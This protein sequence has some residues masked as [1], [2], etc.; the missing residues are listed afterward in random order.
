MK[1]KIG[2][3]ETKDTQCCCK[4]G[5]EE[6]VS[7][8]VPPPS[9]L[10]LRLSARLHLGLHSRRRRRRRSEPEQESG[11]G[12]QQGVRPRHPVQILRARGEEEGG[13]EGEEE[14]RGGPLVPDGVHGARQGDVHLKQLKKIVNTTGTKAFFSTG[15][16]PVP[17]DCSRFLV[18]DL[19]PPGAPGPFRGTRFVCP[20]G[21]RFG[22]LK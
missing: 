16:F 10:L 4:D 15:T 2:P 1:S 7:A 20:T 21:T 3:K 14:G 19:A 17:G 13:Q 11:Q 12:R 9:R 8:L 6:D 22:H 5:G 18:C